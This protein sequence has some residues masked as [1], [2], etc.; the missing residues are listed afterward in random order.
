MA[1]I[2]ESPLGSYR[3]GPRQDPSAAYVV[4][5]WLPPCAQASASA[6]QHYGHL[7]LWM[8]QCRHRGVVTLLCDFCLLNGPRLLRLRETPKYA[9]K[10]LLLI[11]NPLYKLA[12]LFLSESTTSLQGPGNIPL[13]PSLGHSGFPHRSCPPVS[14]PLNRI[15]AI[16]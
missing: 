11:A 15:L 8:L 10:V 13:I 1:D 12:S 4:V 5:P 3:A 6:R 7:Y 16:L 9:N 2:H 14:S